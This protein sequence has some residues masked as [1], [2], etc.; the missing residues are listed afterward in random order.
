MH[1]QRHVRTARNRPSAS[2]SPQR[3]RTEHLPQNSSRADRA[4]ADPDAANHR[5]GHAGR[6]IGLRAGRYDIRLDA[7][8]GGEPLQGVPGGAFRRRGLE[9]VV[10]DRVVVRDERPLTQILDRRERT[11]QLRRLAPGSRPAGQTIVA[12]VDLVVVLAAAAEP[13]LHARLLDRCLVQAEHEGIPALVCITKSDLGDARAVAAA[14]EPRRQAGYPIHRVSL[15]T[16]AGLADLARELEGRV[17]VLVGQSGVG[18]SSL[19]RALRPSGIPK[20]LSV[21]PRVGATSAATGRGTHTTTEVQWYDLPDGG[22]VIDTPG[23]REFGLWDLPAAEVAACFPEF[24]AHAGGC[25]FGTGCTHAHEAGCTVQAAVRAGSIHPDRYDSYLRLTGYGAFE[26]T[27]DGRTRRPVEE[28]FTCRH[29]ASQ[30][31][32][33]AAGTGHRNHCPHCLW[34]RHL[35]RNPGDRAAACGGL[36][37]PAAIM[38]RPGGEWA[39]IHRCVECG[40]YKA[41]RIAGDDHEYGLLALA[42]RPLAHPPFPL[43]RLPAAARGK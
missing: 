27:G 7:P 42:A 19:V 34:S 1:H 30:V 29:C 6:V 35:D 31:P 16:G 23:V 5:S 22:A 25:G 24:R 12:N 40:V 33:R 2:T 13:E 18:K 28:D 4:D 32:A 17:S 11:N 20:G 43:D 36:M 39:I 3:G 26:H 9:I 21:E 41:N 37:E 38:V 14:I 10:G 8:A 15:V